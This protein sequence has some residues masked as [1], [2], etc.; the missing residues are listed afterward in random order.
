MHDPNAAAASTVTQSNSAPPTA[1]DRRL[2]R[3]PPPKAYRDTP[4][5]PKNANQLSGSSASKPPTYSSH[6]HPADAQY[7]S[8]DYDSYPSAEQFGGY[9]GHDE[10][11]PPLPEPHATP[12][13]SRYAAMG[14]PA[15]ALAAAMMGGRKPM[16]KQR[17]PPQHD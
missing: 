6:T 5:P 11:A 1:A 3:A 2:A 9:H 17:Q 12:P 8:S 13:A 16:P 15:A 10:P 7:C 14:G 4:M